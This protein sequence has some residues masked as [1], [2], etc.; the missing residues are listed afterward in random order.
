MLELS[1]RL[2]TLVVMKRMV[3]Q[4]EMRVTIVKGKAKK[5]SVESMALSLPKLIMSLSLSHAGQLR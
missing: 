1:T 4:K 5:R 3:I 2:L